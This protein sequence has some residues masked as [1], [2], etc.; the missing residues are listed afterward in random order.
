VDAPVLFGLTE[1]RVSYNEEI[2]IHAKLDG[3]MPAIQK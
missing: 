2:S 3:C 1:D